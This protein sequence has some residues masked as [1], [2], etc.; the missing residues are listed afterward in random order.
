MRLTPL[1]LP[2]TSA[3]G[4][5]GHDGGGRLVNAYPEIASAGSRS[6]T[7]IMACDGLKLWSTVGDGPVRAMQPLGAMLYV[8]SGR[9]V[10]EIDATGQVRTIGG[11][12]ADGLV[13]TAVNRRRPAT[14]IGIVAGGLYYVIEDRTL[15]QVADVDLPPANSVTFLDGY[16]VL[17]STKGT[18]SLTGID[19]AKDIAALDFATAES[20]P[21]GLI[22][23]AARQRDLVLFGPRTIEFWQYAPSTFPY[24]RATAIEVGC[25][26]A[27]SVAKLEQT[28]LWVADDGTVRQL[29]GY[30]GRRVSTH[31]VERSISAETAKADISAI[32]W[33]RDGH[34]FYSVSGTDWTWQHDLTTGAWIERRSGATGRWRARSVAEHNGLRLIGDRSSG[35]IFEMAPEHADEDGEHLIWSV[36]IPPVSGWP[37]RARIASV[38]LDVVPGQGINTT[39]PHSAEPE[40]MLDWSDDGGHSW[41]GYQAAP[42]GRIG[43]RSRRLAF[44]RLGQTGEDGRFFRMAVSAAVVRGLTGAA[45]E[46]EAGRS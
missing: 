1:A 15:K 38:F 24:A 14:Q 19:S 8:V 5:F 40:V 12:P 46:L 35:K 2:R 32:T 37:R 22:M 28:L 23:S 30:Q 6:P 36:T 33:T 3:P 7:P 11:I 42:A 20:H 43:E 4:R 27:A 13:T 9:V 10:F 18:F 44:R 29:D 17:T 21:D 45:A 34:A 26:A 41:G 16:F 39:A 25:L 31:D